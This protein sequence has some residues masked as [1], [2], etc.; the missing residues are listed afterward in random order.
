MKSSA[1]RRSDDLQLPKDAP[2]HQPLGDGSD[3][4]IAGQDGVAALARIV[5]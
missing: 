2:L 3:R 4:R 5:Q 1:R